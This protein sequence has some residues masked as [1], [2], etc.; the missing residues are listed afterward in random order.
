MKISWIKSAKDYNSFRIFKGMGFDVYDVEDPDLTDEKIEELVQKDYDTI[1]IS[2][3]LSSFSEG[4]IKKYNKYDDV[5][6]IIAP[7]KRE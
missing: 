2:N 1:V 3:E 5:K 4:I 6:I 7:S